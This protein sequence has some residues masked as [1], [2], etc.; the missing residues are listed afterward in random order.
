MKHLKLI[1]L[2]FAACIASAHA[3]S[4]SPG[5]NAESVKQ[6]E[7]IVQTFQTAIINKDA[8]TLGA[9]FLAKDNSWLTVASDEMYAS[10]KKK[11][12]D[13][14]KT[15]AGN[16]KQFVDM[17]GAST[18]PMEEKFSNVRIDTNGSIGSVYFD[19]VFLD[20]GAVNNRGSEAWHLVKTDEGWKISSMIYSVGH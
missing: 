15:M 16:Y 4:P 10:I 5:S 6:I 3:A 17:V 2:L 13:A 7:Q 20:D 14:R 8:K 19:F 1:A 12:P 9:L 18:K 11:H